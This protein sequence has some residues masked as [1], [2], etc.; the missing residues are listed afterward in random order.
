LIGTHALLQPDVVYGR[1]GLVV[2][3]EQHRF[4]VKQRVGLSKKG[5]DP[6]ILVMTATPI[7]RTLAFILYGDLDVSVMDERPPGRRPV[8]TKATDAGGRAAAYS[9]IMKELRAG[10]QAYVVAPLIEDSDELALR[11]ATGIYEELSKFFSGFSVALVHGR[12]RQTEKDTAMDAFYAG[13]ADVLVS[14]VLIEVGVNVPN[15][16]VMLIEN[17]ERF[18]LAQ[19]HQLRGRV[20]RGPARSYCILITDGDSAEAAERARIMFSTDDGFVI[21]EKDL[22]LRGPGEFFG[23]RQHGIPQLRIAN[24]A[25]HVKILNA[26]KSEAERILSD[27]P[28]LDKPENAALSAAVG[29][30]FASASD[31]GI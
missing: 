20:G 2:T 12:M 14:T 15:A 11:S 16:T 3:D 28:S 8:V 5:V 4:G 17:A 19:L 29:S 13:A 31:I 23:V 10:H 26:V 27:D 24:L 6:D 21:A 9:F 7:P 25:K 1:L 18:G 22:E 30:F